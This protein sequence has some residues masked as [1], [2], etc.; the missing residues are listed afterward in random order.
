MASYTVVQNV[1]NR[2]SVF[3]SPRPTVEQ[4]LIQVN[5]YGLTSLTLTPVFYDRSTTLQITDTG[6]ADISLEQPHNI[7]APTPCIILYMERGYDPSIAGSV[8]PSLILTIT[9]NRLVDQI[10][11]TLRHPGMCAATLC[12][13]GQRFWSRGVPVG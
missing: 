3:I 9:L 12:Q 10:W 6:F 5:R 1:Q 4:S 8:G 13:Q 11:H 2:A 7:Y